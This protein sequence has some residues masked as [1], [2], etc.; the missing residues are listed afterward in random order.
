M[1]K[2]SHKKV[3]FLLLLFLVF[4]FSS[5]VHAGTLSVTRYEQEK[6]NWCW[7][8]CAKM[9]GKYVS[10]TTYS[11]SQ[12]CSKIK[13]SIVNT[14]ASDTEVSNALKYT[15]GKSIAMYSKLTYSQFVQEID[16]QNTP[17]TIAMFWPSSLSAHNLVVSGCGYGGQTLRLVDPASDCGTAWYSYSDLCNGTTI[18]SGT[19]YYGMTWYVS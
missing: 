1:K 12:I 10:G 8:A 14:S 16:S 17:V 15:T 4:S 2:M 18:Q 6:T 9:M 5:T 3:V 13:G 19:G 7:A 11:Q